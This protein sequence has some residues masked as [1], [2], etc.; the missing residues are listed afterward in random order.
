M[1]FVIKDPKPFIKTLTATLQATEARCT[2]PVLANVRI[3]TLS[4]KHGSMYCTDLEVGLYMNFSAVVGKVGALTIPGKKALDILKKL[5]KKENISFESIDNNFVKISC[6]KLSYKLAGASVEDYPTIPNGNASKHVATVNSAELLAAIAQVGYAITKE[7]TRYA[8][9]GIAFIPEDGKL[10]LATTDAHRLTTRTIDVSAQDNME[11]V[12]IPLKTLNVMT[13]LLKE[14]KKQVFGIYRTDNHLFFTNED[15]T[16]VLDSRTLEGQFP[17]WNKVI[18]KGNDKEYVV[19][20]AALAE[21]VGMVSLMSH[22]TSR[23]VKFTTSPEAFTVSASNPELGEA[24]D[25]FAIES[26]YGGEG[27]SFGINSKYLL[28]TLKACDT[29]LVTFKLLD[30]SACILIED[31]SSQHALMPMRI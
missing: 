27:I 5:S 9:N 31:S 30:E 29:E 8:L 6:G 26:G 2:R 15:D 3:E 22:E 19:N 12:V 13:K 23:A 10:R 7:E 1:H 11:Q 18:P 25:S 28:E 24:E 16:F 20:K 17:D 21:T 14:C 4:D